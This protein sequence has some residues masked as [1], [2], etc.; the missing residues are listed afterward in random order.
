MAPSPRCVSLRLTVVRPKCV[1]LEAG[2]GAAYMGNSSSGLLGLVPG[3][4]PSYMG[5]CFTKRIE[6]W[7]LS[8]VNSTHPQS[9]V[10]EA[11]LGAAFCMGRMSAF[12]ACG[13]ASDHIR[14]LLRPASAI[15]H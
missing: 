4:V 6:N 15:R 10:L 1:F 12:R 8:P 13:L 7:N 5:K 2:L 14:P 3:L 9:A 11:R